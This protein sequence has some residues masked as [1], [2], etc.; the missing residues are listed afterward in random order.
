VEAAGAGLVA[1]DLVSADRLFTR[2]P[3]ALSMA[4]DNDNLRLVVDRSLSRFYRSPEFHTLYLKTFGE[5]TTGALLFYQVSAL[6]D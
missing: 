2:E 4:R 3:I 1:G 5:P 6:P